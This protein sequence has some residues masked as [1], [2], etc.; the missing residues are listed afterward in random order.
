MLRILLSRLTFRPIWT[1]DLKPRLA[2]YECVGL[3]AS[4]AGKYLQLRESGFSHKQLIETNAASY[5]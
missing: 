2:G 5:T 3:I 4:A 1:L